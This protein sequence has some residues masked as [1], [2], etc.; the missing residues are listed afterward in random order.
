MPSSLQTVLESVR[1]LSPSSPRWLLEA[2]LLSE[3]L[4]DSIV[5]NA[6]YL[7]KLR[8]ALRERAEELGCDWI[9]GASDRDESMVGELPIASSTRSRVLVF[10]LVRVTGASFR[11]TEERLQDVEIVPNVL[12]DLHD[13]ESASNR[14]QSVHNLEKLLGSKTR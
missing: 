5:S 6:D 1:T 7:N 3:E 4:A 8:V 2:S 9:V 13:A 14:H 11:Q 12:I 10:E